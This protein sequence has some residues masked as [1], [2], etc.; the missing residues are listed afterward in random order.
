MAL[1]VVGHRAGSAFLHRQAG[2]GAV[3]RLDLRLF[4][5]REDDGMGG[6]I[7]IK[8]DNIAQLVD[9]LRVVGELEL[10]DP[11]RLETMRSP[12]A[13]DGTRADTDGFRHH[14]SSPMGRLG[15][16]IGPGERHNTLGDIRP[17]WW[18]ARGSSSQVSYRTYRDLLN[19]PILHRKELMLAENHPRREE[20]QALTEAAETIGLFRDPT[21][22]GFRELWLR[23]VRESGYQIVGHEL[24]PIANDETTTA[25]DESKIN[26]SSI[27]RHLTALVRQ[28]FSAPVQALARYGF[29]SPSVEVLDY[30][31]GRG[32]DIRGLTANGIRAYGWDPYYAPDGPRQ[33]AD[34]VNLGFVINVIEDLDER[35]EALRNAYAFTKKVMAVAAMLTS[36]A[37]RLGR[38]YRDGFVTSRNT[39]QK[40]YTQAQ[41]AGFIVDMLGDEPVPVSPGVFFVF[42][43]K[44][45]EQSFLAGRQRNVTLLQRLNRSE[46]GRVRVPRPDRIQVKYEANREAVD[47]LWQTCLRLGREPDE[48][49]IDQL[50]SLIQGFGSLS[51][52]LRFTADLKDQ[53][54]LTRARESRVADLSV[55]LALGQFAKRKPYKHLEPGLQRDIRNFF[56]GFSNAQ[57]HARQQL[58]EIADTEKISAACITAAE[59]GLGWLVE[60]RYLQLHTSLIERLP[61]VL[62]IYI[63]CGSVLY[64]D[65]QTADLIK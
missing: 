31:C 24:I 1:V 4:V 40:Y 28:G 48:T 8:P 62:R 64:G 49:E 20:F 46:S 53:T 35:T 26:G 33:E 17:E 25:S 60:G 56:G 3:E 9:E 21:R 59:Q 50:E 13:L 54:L 61:T 18:D 11:V 10:V 42:R 14:S 15:G 57:H 29:I 37:T 52:A 32:D 7:D 38:P 41:L 36:Q 45:L 44:D 58:F 22:I 23:L 2:L 34:V 12:D 27:A 39:F 63:A 6:R 16:R 47:A 30:G 51:R 65:V 55:Y 5:D 19:P 43:D